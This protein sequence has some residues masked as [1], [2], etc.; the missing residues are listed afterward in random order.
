M[1]RAFVI[2]AILLAPLPTR[3]ARGETPSLASATVI[4]YNR[5]AADG[6]SLAKFYA[7]QRG[8]PNDHI[9]GLTCS[10]Q[11]EISR[12]EYDSDIADPLR[13]EFKDRGWW[14]VNDAPNNKQV[15][16]STT[17]H[18][19]ALIKGIPLKIH[20]TTA[21][22]VG[23]QWGGGPVASRNEACVDSELAALPFL[24]RQISGAIPNPY[25]ESFRGIFE[26]EGIAPLLV[27]RL[28]GPNASTVRRMI[29]D[30]I[31]TEK[32]GLWGR[33]Y[34]DGSRNTANGYEI[35]DKWMAEIVQQMH[36][37]G[38]PVVYDDL[39][40]VFPDGYPITDC[41]LYYGWYAG[42]ITG[43][44]SAPN[45]RFIPGA[46]AVHIH[47]YSAS[48]LRDP[49]ANWVAPLLVHGAA[50]SMG[51]V[52]EPYL[53]LTSYLDTFND[54]LM[55]GM[56]FAESAYIS[57]HAVS[58]MNTV[59]GD[60]LY[61]P[62]A[63]WQQTAATPAGDWRVYH[64]FAVKNKGKSSEE[65]F[66]LARQTAARTRNGAMIEDLGSIQARDGNF[67]NAI[68]LF[69][70]ARATYG[71]RDDIIRVVLEEADAWAKLN[72]PRK[73]ADL[74]RSVLR[75]ISSDVPAIP[76]LRRVADGLPA[77]PPPAP[78]PSPTTVR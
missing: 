30:A 28:D 75:I 62:F 42:G 26:F 43:P 17:I 11:E 36:K 31:A 8:I 46:I 33:A 48:T 54:R 72:K 40:S 7:Q 22:Y 37:V 76:L 69:Q 66:Q 38:V 67:Q 52:Y 63:T 74:A 29:T 1:R 2:L 59:V 65:Y 19:V 60:P 12:E 77:V 50:C 57:L 64:D 78:S 4:V 41:S 25:F 44:F 53:Q 70:Q 23:D 3:V 32:T 6:P 34:V 21:T 35:G 45:F 20:S 68:A 47:S 56:T 10:V 58:W 71:K 39:P 61:R 27:T 13:K 9:I 73:G 24:T 18:F 5:Q 51:N 55:R 49:N 16:A 14:T 15:L